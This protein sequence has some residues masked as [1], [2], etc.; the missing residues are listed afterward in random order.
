MR[1]LLCIIAALCMAPVWAG[2][3]ANTRV[4]P[5]NSSTVVGLTTD[6][7]RAGTCQ[8]TGS[9]TTSTLDASASATNDIYVG[10]SFDLAGGSCAAAGSDFLITDYDGA[11]KLVTFTPAAAGSSSASCTFIV[12][13]S[14]PKS[15]KQLI[16]G[17]C[18]GT[19]Y[20]AIGN[21]DSSNAQLR[22]TLYS[23]QTLALGNFS[24]IPGISILSVSATDTPF[25]MWY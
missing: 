14:L 17:G 11:S 10:L 13:P 19:C 15:G 4:I 3:P 21:G 6:P 22:M 1:R 9:T 24:N 20:L 12:G 8:A 7:V 16:I 2:A 5:V 18:T 23:S 25:M